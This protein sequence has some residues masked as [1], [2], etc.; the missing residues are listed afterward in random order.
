MKGEGRGC[1]IDLT[2]KRFGR[3][4]VERR[5][6]A[7][8]NNNGA[9]WVCK[10]DCGVEVAVASNKLR[11][12]NTKSCGCLRS[13]TFEERAALGYWPYRTDGVAKCES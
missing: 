2:G 9:V 11:Y 6:P 8:S 7:K 5:Y 10:C 13:M 12:G 3:L 4:V 1:P